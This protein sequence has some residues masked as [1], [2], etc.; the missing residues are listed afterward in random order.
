VL[1]N[2]K[3]KKKG[4]EREHFKENA[5]LKYLPSLLFINITGGEKPFVGGTDP[6]KEEE[7]K[8][9]GGRRRST[10][11][12]CQGEIHDWINCVWIDCFDS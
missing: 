3:K 10:A 2:K 11:L 7:G 5:N 1:N 12:W 4:K 6:R 9:R 8:T